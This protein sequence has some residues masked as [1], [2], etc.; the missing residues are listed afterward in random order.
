MRGL[1]CICLSGG[2][3]RNEPN[4]FVLSAH[5]CHDR[6]GG[7]GDLEC[8]CGMREVELTRDL[9]MEAGGW[10]EMKSAR[11]MHRGGLVSEASYEKRCK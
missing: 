10:R 8:L 6:S 11:G 2:S 7:G 3:R 1:H 5:R 4:N 9:L